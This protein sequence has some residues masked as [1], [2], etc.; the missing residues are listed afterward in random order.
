MTTSSLRRFA[1]RPMGR[2]QVVCFPHAGGAASTYR[3][4]AVDAPWD[5]EIVSVQYPGREDRFA[6]RP[7]GGLVELAET[8]AAE[9]LTAER[10]FVLFGHSFGALVAYEVACRLT[11]LARPPAGLVVS[12]QPAPQLSRGGRL[13]LGADQELITDV[14]RL[15]GTGDAVLS[16]DGLLAA[17]LPAIRWDY[18][19]SETYRSASGVRL[20]M[21]VTALRAEDDPEVDAHEAAGW[22][23]VTSAD[24]TWQVFPGGHFYLHRD[25]VPAL[26]AVVRAARRTPAAADWLSLP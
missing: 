8:V 22:A 20:N 9:L 13:H 12:G 3:S 6:E 10:P 18:T 4:W 23:E 11:V 7:V 24:C 17:L 21:P 26:A 2:V 16:A 14:R 19:L 25:P 1:R 15:G 5:V